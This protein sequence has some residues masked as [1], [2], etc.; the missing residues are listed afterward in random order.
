M[1]MLE[2][3]GQPNNQYALQAIL[4]D[5]YKT[6]TPEQIQMVTKAAP[7]NQ[8]LPKG[9]TWEQYTPEQ[10][11]KMT[12]SIAVSNFLPA[13]KGNPVS[14]MPQVNAAPGT[15]NKSITT[16]PT[17]TQGGF[18]LGGMLGG[19]GNALSNPALLSMAVGTGLGLAS[20]QLSPIQSL[21]AGA[22]GAQG[23]LN[24]TRED[25]RL[26]AELQAKILAA[27]GFG[28]GVAP[29][30]EYIEKAKKLY[31]NARPDQLTGLAQGLL[32]QDTTG[33]AINVQQTR[34]VFGKLGSGF[35]GTGIGGLTGVE[36]VQ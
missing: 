21:G 20:G 18:D 2:K 32:E 3:K 25:D 12:S 24:Q 4:G 10:I 8:F 36:R 6:L 30:S 29:L 31:P 27:K 28:T 17:Q 15:P 22:M 14:L 23:I 7:I 16:E 34:S 1:A 11:Q 13:P 33:K 26:N 5:K 35:L 19:I 9:K